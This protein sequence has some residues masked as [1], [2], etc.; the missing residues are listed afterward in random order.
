MGACMSAPES[1]ALSAPAPRHASDSLALPPPPPPDAT[2]PPPPPPPVSVPASLSL[3]NDSSHASSAVAVRDVLPVVA[4]RPAPT[5]PV[6]TSVSSAST[7][8]NC[9]GLTVEHAAP[10]TYL[11]PLPS[12]PA[13]K[14]LFLSVDS[15]GGSS[16]SHPPASSLSPPSLSSSSVSVQFEM[17]KSNSQSSPPPPPP[18]PAHPLTPISILDSERS[19]TSPYSPTPR[20]PPPPATPVERVLAAAGDCLCTSDLAVAVHAAAK[21]LDGAAFVAMYR[22]QRARH[23]AL[24]RMAIALGIDTQDVAWQVKHGVCIPA[25]DQQPQPQSPLAGQARV[26]QQQSPQQSLEVQ[27]HAASV[28]V[29]AANRLLDGSERHPLAELAGAFERAREKIARAENQE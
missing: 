8:A 6:S 5:A 7:V 14:S 3:N 26:L 4:R 21:M 13:G 27:V 20:A 17:K 1:A 24:A 23:V 2:P 15:A 18:P 12:T 25:L 19:P 11:L 16:S 29:A 9:S 22:T 10:P 28:L